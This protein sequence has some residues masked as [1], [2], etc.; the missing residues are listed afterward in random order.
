MRARVKGTIIVGDIV[1]CNRDK[2]KET[3]IEADFIEIIE[4]P[5]KPEIRNG[6]LE[7]SLKGERK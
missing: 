5:K 7:T 3:E 4:E 1:R 2:D 6:N